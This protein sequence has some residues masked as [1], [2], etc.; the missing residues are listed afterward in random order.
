MSKFFV[1]RDSFFGEKILISNE[2]VNHITKVLRLLE[3]DIIIVCDCEGTDYKAEIEKIEKH[4]VTLRIL[5]S[6]KSMGEPSIKV[7]LYQGLPKAS[8]LDYII[9]KTVELG[10]NKIVPVITNRTVVKIENDKA[11]EAKTERWQ[12]IAYEAAK[13]CGRGILP[14][15]EKP[16]LFDELLL[17]I[18]SHE[19]IIMLYENEKDNSLKNTLALHKNATDIAIIIGP[20]GGFAQNEVQRAIE[21]GAKTAGLGSRILRTETAPVSVVSVLMYEYNQL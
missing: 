2:D 10:I 6:Y 18:P 1:K 12:K 20:E 8:K 15:V 11:A 5:E 17:R 19:L 16:L 21:A 14:Q 4:L 9:Q 13:Q 7:T 3:K